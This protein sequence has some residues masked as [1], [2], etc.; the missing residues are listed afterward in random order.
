MI[1]LDTNILVRILVKD[2][3]E[4]ANLVINFIKKNRSQL[5]VNSIVFCELIWVLESCYDYSKQDIID[6]L[7]QVL[8]TKQFLI[9]EKEIIRQ[10][11]DLYKKTKID[12]SDA[13]IAYKNKLENCNYTITFDKQAAKAD[14]YKLLY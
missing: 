6:C 14:L 8:K 12:F 13:L 1:G 11:L 3:E 7:V 9:P 4:Q 5:V 10:S 2:D